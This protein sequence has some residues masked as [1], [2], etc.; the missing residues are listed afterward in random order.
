MFIGAIVGV[1]GA[2]LG[3]YSSK[4][5]NDSAEKQQ[6]AA[7]EAAKGDPR[8][9]EMLYGNG[10]DNQGLLSQYQ[11]MLGK[12]QSAGLSTYGAQ[13]DGYLGYQAGQ[14][15][16]R[17]REAAYTQMQG[18]TPSTVTPGSVI[19]APQQNGMNLAGSYDKFINGDAGA[20]PYL[21]R[22]IQG[23]IDQSTNQFRQMQGEAT[24]NLQ[25]NILPGIRSN[26]VL[27]GQYGSSRQGVAEGNAISDMTKQLN[28]S[29][30]QFGQNNTNQAVGAQ[31]SSFNQGQD[32]ALA[33]TQGLGAQQYGV[34]GQ[35]AGFQ[36]QANLSNQNNQLQTNQMNI[37]NQ[38][39]GMSNLSGI[40]GGAYTNGQNQDNRA[41]NQ[42][43]QVNGLLQPYL[44]KPGT[45]VQPAYQSSTAGSILG[46]AAAG[47]GLYNQF[48]QMSKPE[49]NGGVPSTSTYAANNWFS[50]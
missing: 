3:A 14:D 15:Q 23:G 11:S 36:Q 49:S 26:S 17:L 47:L 41:L 32:R 39:A 4:K 35:N 25:R 33:A 13:Q 21:T 8:A 6:A 9:L 42:A 40:I 2:L 19:N 18:N 37:A 38:Q 16:N 43:T 1:G 46:G 29:M 50:E 12:P 31:A 10:G 27:A 20:N 7:I 48:N 24:D 44:A 22:A 34:A 28:Q 45:A 5:T 30:T